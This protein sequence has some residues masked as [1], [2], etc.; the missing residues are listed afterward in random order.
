VNSASGFDLSTCTFSD[1]VASSNK[2][3][4]IFI[5]GKKFINIITQQKLKDINNDVE[6]DLY[7]IDLD[8]SGTP[9]QTLK[10]LLSND[11]TVY[12][13]GLNGLVSIPCGTSTNPCKY[14]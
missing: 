5:I 14:V 1:C 7:G 2:G 13:N 6:N 12:M 8:V 3:H 11:R 9:L 4:N 10:S